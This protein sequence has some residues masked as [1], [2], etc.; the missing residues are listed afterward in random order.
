MKFS[1]E[2]VA[3]SSHRSDRCVDGLA[4]LWLLLDFAQ[5]GGLV[6]EGSR[7]GFVGG[8]FCILWPGGPGHFNLTGRRRFEPFGCALTP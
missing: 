6:A 2:D 3:D 7:N 8:D 4:K 1:Y 5:K